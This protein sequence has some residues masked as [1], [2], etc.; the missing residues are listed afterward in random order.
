MDSYQIGLM[1]YLLTVRIMLFYI[2]IPTHINY[3]YFTSCYLDCNENWPVAK[4]NIS[5]INII[6]DKYRTYAYLNE[7]L[8]GHNDSVCNSPF[9]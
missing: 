9:L 8:Y 4:L 1:L 5:R 6:H 2:V 3:M 7:K